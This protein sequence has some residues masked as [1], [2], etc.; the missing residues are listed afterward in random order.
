MTTRISP[1]LMMIAALMLLFSMCFQPVAADDNDGIDDALE[2]QLA[3]KFAPYLNFHPDEAF[4][5]ISPEYAVSRSNLNTTDGL[6]ASNPTIESLASYTNLSA[7]YFL[8]NLQG[9]VED[10]GIITDFLAV[11]DTYPPTVHAR[12]TEGFDGKTVYVIQY[13]FFYPFNKGPMNT[14]EGD[15]EMVMVVADTSQEPLFAAYSQ[16]LA[17]EKADW[18]LV[19]KTGDHPYVY[20]AEGSHAN[21]FKSYEGGLGLANDRVS[22]SGKILGPDDYELV[23]LGETGSGNHPIDQSW[24][25]FA[26][27]WGEYGDVDAGVRGMRGPIGPAYMDDA[28]RWDDPMG[29]S[30]GLQHAS[31]N[32]FTANWLVSN[33]LLIVF[34]IMFLILL[35]QI[36]GKFRLRKK[37][38]TLGPRLFPFL[39]VDGVNLKSIGLIIGI[40]A[41][42]FGIVGFLL[43]WYTMYINV[44]TGP[45]ATSGAI[46]ILKVDGLHGVAFNRLDSGNGLVQVFGLPIPF[47]WMLMA[48]LGLFFFGIVGLHRSRKMGRKLISRGMKCLVP[49]IVIV[50]FFS[51][52]ASIV[53]SYGFDTP[54]EVEKMI[55]MLSDHPFGGEVSENFGEYGLTTL[56]WGLAPGAYFL[57]LSF[58]LF[59]VAGLMEI[60]ANTEY[61]EGVEDE[62]EEFEDEMDGTGEEGEP[63]EDGDEDNPPEPYEQGD[64]DSPPEPNTGEEE[65]PPPPADYEEE[66]PPPPPPAPEP[67][68]EDEP[69][70]E[71]YLP[72]PPPEEGDWENPPAP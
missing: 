1:C 38:G 28:E 26:G 19:D 3:Q 37:N 2:L 44:A 51:M 53:S 67:V 68:S 49:I 11:R 43:P 36:I 21:Y 23:M 62:E 20:V 17:G 8:D 5:P 56:S 16:H 71:D 57:I 35:A 6:V 52:L 47:T 32:W 24:L 63:P 12:V 58:V 59:L 69:V 7:N 4:Y 27:C 10:E 9:T 18:L 34:G 33:F 40:V 46:K 39:Y 65:L 70:D 50:A 13:W 15:W 64:L 22:G 48:S 29:W 45:F 66:L 60:V 61:Y 25:D 42:V 55:I 54:S 31:Q 72:P 41:L 30:G 14:H